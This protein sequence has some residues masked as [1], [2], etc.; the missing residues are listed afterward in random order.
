MGSLSGRRASPSSDRGGKVG[1]H[2]IEDTTFDE[3][4]GNIENGMLR[5]DMSRSFDAATL[6]YIEYTLLPKSIGEGDERQ[7]VLCEQVLA[8]YSRAAPNHV[9]GL[10][11]PLEVPRNELQV[12]EL[13]ATRLPEYG[14]H[15]VCSQTEFPDW[16]LVN[17]E[18]DFIYTEVEHRSSSFSDHQHDVGN[19]DLIACWEHDWPD[20]PLP[21]L[22]FFSGT[23]FKPRPSGL[24]RKWKGRLSVNFAGRLSRYATAQTN[25]RGGQK[26]GRNEY[27]LE[28][29]ADLN[30]AGKSRAEIVKTLAVELG[31]TRNAMSALL[32]KQ[33][34]TDGLR[35]GENMWRVCERVHELMAVGNA[36][37][38]AITQA[39]REFNLKRG[40]VQSYLSRHKNR[41]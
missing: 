1:K 2:G 38:P 5:P 35:S 4:M 33:G 14:Y 6:D 34:V 21:V 13:F 15:L 27:M 37:A 9:S 22:E 10:W 29:Y 39:A 20:S 36:K 40:T 8:K 31:V 24:R 7:A 19:C 32:R 12:R 11:Q 28:R 26:S 17:N 23:H 16:L 18:G 41:S 25:Q 3:A 30:E